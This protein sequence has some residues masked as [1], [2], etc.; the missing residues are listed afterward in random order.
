MSSPSTSIDLESVLKLQTASL[1]ATPSPPSQPVPPSLHRHKILY[2]SSLE[3]SLYTSLTPTTLL[4]PLIGASVPTHFIN[5]G[6]QYLLITRGFSTP[7][8]GFGSS[9]RNPSAASRLNILADLFIG[10]GYTPVSNDQYNQHRR[11]MRRIA[12]TAETLLLDANNRASNPSHSCVW[13][14]HEIQSLYF[15]RAFSTVLRVTPLLI[16]E[17]FV[18]SYID[19]TDDLYDVALIEVSEML[20]ASY[21]W[22][23]NS[24]PGNDRVWGFCAACCSLIGELMNPEVNPKIVENVSIVG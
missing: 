6:D 4:H 13:K 23:G 11:Y 17:K 15:M 1:N 3:R 7:E 8:N 20:V 24:Y 10:D 19:A 9:P 18:F 2:G 22:D 21:A 14:R 16:S 5:A 12:I